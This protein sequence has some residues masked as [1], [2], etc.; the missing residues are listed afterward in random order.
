MLDLEVYITKILRVLPEMIS[1]DSI[2]SNPNLLI[3]HEILL[4]ILYDHRS[5]VILVH[6]YGEM[7][8]QAQELFQQQM[9]QY[10][11]RELLVNGSFKKD[12]EMYEV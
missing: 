9:H 1:D 3:M 12:S 6:L 8:D 11:I 10:D 2:N 4:L 7:N 5:E